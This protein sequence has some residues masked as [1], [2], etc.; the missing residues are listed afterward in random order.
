MKVYIGIDWSSQKHDIMYLNEEGG[1]IAYQTIPHTPLG[2]EAFDDQ[3]MKLG[4]GVE[5]CLVGIETEHNLLI[6]FLSSRQYRQIYVIPPT[7][8]KGSRGRFGA[9][10]ANTDR[11]DAHLIADMLRTDRA[12]LHVW[13]ADSLLTQQ[14]AAL[15]SL[16]QFLTHMIIQTNNRLRNVLWRYY[17]NAAIVFSALDLQISLEFICAFPTPQAAAQL[18]FEQF[19]VFARSHHYPQPSK[20][21]ACFARLQKP[22]PEARQQTVLAFQSEAVRLARLSF[23]AVQDKAAT[24]REIQELFLEHPDYP[25]F[26]SLPGAGKILAPALLAK[27]GDDRLRYPTPQ[28]LQSVAGTC[29]V[30][31]ASGKHK[32]VS[33]RYACD[34]EFRSVVQQWAKCSIDASV[35]AYT[36]FQSIRPH[37]DSLSHAYRRLANRW[38]EIAWRLWQD[39]VPYDE[40]RHLRQHA[41]RVKPN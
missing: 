6:D 34:H 17:P 36:Y 13:H 12:R 19:K 22:Q 26:S 32:V 41:L 31:R 38:L 27:F 33:F 5:D 21:P 11:S 14:I 9:S 3:R 29:P 7:T 25:I 16:E 40:E 24:I 37:C 15:A 1:I 2:F 30:T 20:L 4:V 10:K 39:R 28:V 8:I 35:W 18:T 23:H